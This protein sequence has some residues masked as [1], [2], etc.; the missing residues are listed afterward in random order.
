[1]QLKDQIIRHVNRFKQ[2]RNRC[3][4]GMEKALKIKETL[5]DRLCESERAACDRVVYVFVC[6]CM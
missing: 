5:E 3:E 4:P 2:A 1:M 6:V